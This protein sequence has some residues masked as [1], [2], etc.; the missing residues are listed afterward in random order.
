MFFFFNIG[1]L[2]VRN[3]VQYRYCVTTIESFST[4]PLRPFVNLSW[5]Q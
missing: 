3:L 2:S 4:I 5:F 1:T